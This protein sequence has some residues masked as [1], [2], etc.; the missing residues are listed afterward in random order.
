MDNRFSRQGFLGAAGQAAIDQV[1]VGICGLGGGGSH[2]ATQLAHLGVL[3]YKLFDADGAEETNLNRT[4]TLIESDVAAGTLKVEAARR[5]ILE[6][7]SAARVEAMPFQWQD[8]AETLRTCDVVFGSVD[9]F[10]ER[11]DLEATCRRFLI[12]LIDIGMDVTPVTNGPPAMAGQIILSMPGDACM[13]CMGFLNEHNLKLEAQRYG[14]AGDHPQVI[15]AN[16]ILASTAVGVFVDLL[17]NWSGSLRE[18]VHLVYRGN[19]G[20]IRP[21]NRL[22]HV[23]RSCPHYPL[24]QVGEPR[25][26]AV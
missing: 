17:T 26:R 18:R 1:R 8:R 14:A 19:E 15:W 10:S 20:T 11:R 21:D 6:V 2:I 16:G 5:R 4:V 24:D 25:F 22:P 7:R 3:D 9:V 23:P 13:F 12:P